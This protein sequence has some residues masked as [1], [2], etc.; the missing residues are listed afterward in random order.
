MSQGRSRAGR[1]PG[2]W[3]GQQWASSGCS[4]RA[5][6]AR[7][8]GVT[9]GPKVGA[10]LPVTE[11]AFFASCKDFFGRKDSIAKETVMKSLL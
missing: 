4:H 11:I 5:E 2:A 10:G 3:A 8:R 6:P 1:G 9:A 7:E